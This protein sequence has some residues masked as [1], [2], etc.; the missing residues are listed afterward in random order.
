MCD[1]S[2]R[3]NCLLVK[4]CF[5]HKNFLD[6]LMSFEGSDYF[7]FQRNRPRISQGPQQTLGVSIQPFFECM[8]IVYPSGIQLGS[9]LGFHRHAING[10]FLGTFGRQKNGLLQTKGDSTLILRGLVH[11]L[12]WSTIPVNRNV[13]FSN[14]MD[15]MNHLRSYNVPAA[16]AVDIGRVR[17]KKAKLEWPLIVELD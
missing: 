2:I 13:T 11:S 7:T 4:V 15:S 3:V 8:R 5:L 1:F 14:L 10:I 9:F 6:R 16:R 17:C 12:Y